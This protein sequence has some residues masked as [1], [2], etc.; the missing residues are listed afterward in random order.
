MLLNVIKVTVVEQQQDTM[1]LYNVTF[2]STLLRPPSST[3]CPCR[4]Q[5]LTFKV[6]LKWLFW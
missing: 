6:H 1:C 4:G 5:K 3:L 2:F